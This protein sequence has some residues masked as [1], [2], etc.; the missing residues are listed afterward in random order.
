MLMMSLAEASATVSLGGDDLEGLCRRKAHHVNPGFINPWL[1]GGQPG[2]IWRLLQWTL[3]PNPYA[4]AKR[5]PPEF[6]LVQPRVEEIRKGRDS[7]TYL[8]HATFWIRLGGQDIFTDPVFGDVWP[9]YRRH[10]P[11]PLPPEK[12]PIPQMVLI[13]HNH[14]DHLD[15][16]SLHRLGTAPLYLTPLGYKDWFAQTLPG[17]RVIELDW[18]ESLDHRGISFRLLPSQHWTKRTPWDT[19]RWLWGAWLIQ[20]GEKKVFFSGD[21][22]YFFGFREYGK[23][24]GPLDAAILPIGAYEPRWFMKDHHM[25]PEEAVK[26][27]LDLRARV[28]IPQQWGV[29]D[30][31]DEP[32]DLPPQAYR[33]AARAAG[34]SEDRAPLLQPGQTWPFPGN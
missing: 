17:A 31:T 2:S 21:S 20:K 14:Y 4:Q 11:S 19:N 10:V 12:L 18:F 15:R 13:S 33:E 34:L 30:L 28:L 7:I 25:S 27:L 8:G 32:L 9:W 29:F 5:R 22:G 23:K 24:F 16:E 3:S 6:P 26:A 1:P